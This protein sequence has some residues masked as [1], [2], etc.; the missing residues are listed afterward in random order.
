M[1]PPFLCRLGLHWRMKILYCLFVDLVSGK[2]VFEAVC[3]CKKH[4]MIDV[5]HGFPIFKVEMNRH[6]S[7]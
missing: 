7:K 3:P 6:K 2:E 1:K 5:S 4:W